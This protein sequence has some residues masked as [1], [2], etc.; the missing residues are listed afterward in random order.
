MYLLAPQKPK[1][2]LWKKGKLIDQ[3]CPVKRKD[4][5]SLRVK[6]E[7][8][9]RHERDLAMF[10]LVIDSTL[11]ASDLVKVKGVSVGGKLLK[12]AIIIQ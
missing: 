3:K 12:R 7:M 6:L 2:K 9:S 5:W 8:K 10:N 4:I 11:R 1:H